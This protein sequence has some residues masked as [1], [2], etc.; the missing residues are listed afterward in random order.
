MSAAG[1]SQGARAA[2]AGAQH[3]FGAD[4]DNAAVANVALNERFCPA[5]AGHA[6]PGLIARSHP[7]VALSDPV[8]PRHLDECR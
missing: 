5:F 7:Q 3:R 4:P 2:E 6:A 8:F 1:P